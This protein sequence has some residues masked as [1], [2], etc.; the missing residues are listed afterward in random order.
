MTWSVLCSFLI[1]DWGLI[2][3]LEILDELSSS[4][5]GAPCLLVL[6]ALCTFSPEHPAV[7]WGGV[8]VGIYKA[9]LCVWGNCSCWT[10]WTLYSSVVCPFH[11]WTKTSFNM[12]ASFPVAV[13]K[14]SDKGN[15]MEKGFSWLTVL[16]RCSPSR[17]S[18]CEHRQESHGGRAGGSKVT[19]HL[20]LEADDEWEGGQDVK[21]KGLP[22]LPTSS[23]EAPLPKGSTLTEQ[24]HRLCRFNDMSLWGNISYSNIT[25]ILGNPDTGRQ[26]DWKSRFFPLYKEFECT[27]SLILSAFFYTKLL[28]EEWIQ[29][30]L[31]LDSLVLLT[32]RKRYHFPLKNP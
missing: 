17:R 10:V 27:L 4:L 18:T 32:P 5:L 12:S 15:L 25:N 29:I 8:G 21:A 30:P 11:C 23:R 6:V 16:E 28:S 9:C 26:A 14:Y 13:M 3:K 2:E 31:D 1:A 22:Q 24:H 7:A 20:Y 19:L